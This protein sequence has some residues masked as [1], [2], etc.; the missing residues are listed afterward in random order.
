VK[1]KG[2]KAQWGH[3]VTKNRNNPGQILTKTRINTF[4]LRKVSVEA[5]TFFVVVY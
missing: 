3:L 2:Q 5:V 4:E 1:T